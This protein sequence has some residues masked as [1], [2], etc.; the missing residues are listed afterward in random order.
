MYG[1][2]NVV[3]LTTTTGLF[4]SMAISTGFGVL[5]PQATAEYVHEFANDQRSVGFTF[6]Y[7]TGRPRYL[8]QTDEP[9]RNFFNIGLGAVLVLPGGKSVFVNARQLLGYEDRTATTVTAGLR[10]PF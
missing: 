7:A 10:V 1:N 8:F 5:I 9:D 3:S 6:V 4:A 2:Q